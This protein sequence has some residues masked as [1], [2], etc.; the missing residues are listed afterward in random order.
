M[1][2]VIHHPSAYLHHKPVSRGALYTAKRLS[3]CAFRVP[4]PSNSSNFSKVPTFCLSAP[5][6]SRHSPPNTRA[7]KRWLMINSQGLWSHLNKKRSS[8][9]WNYKNNV[10]QCWVRGFALHLY[11]VLCVTSERNFKNNA[12]HHKKI[13]HSFQNFFR[14]QKIRKS[15]NSTDIK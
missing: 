15:R 10:L 13:P 7:A 2:G 4:P 5:E 12:R 8:I 3:T 9:T 11:N 6:P 1:L 14:I